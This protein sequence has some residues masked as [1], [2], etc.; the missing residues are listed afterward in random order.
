[1]VSG[2]G[3]AVLFESDD[4]EEEEED[5]EKFAL[6]RTRNWSDVHGDGGSKGHGVEMVIDCND[7]TQILM[8][9]VLLQWKDQAEGEEG[10]EGVDF[11]PPSP[12]PFKPV[13]RRTSLIQM[14]KR[15]GENRIPIGEEKE[16]GS[17]GGSSRSKQGMIAQT[18]GLESFM[19]NPGGSLGSKSGPSL[20]VAPP[21][22]GASLNAS[23]HPVSS[24]AKRFQLSQASQSMHIDDMQ[25]DT[26][27]TDG[28]L[29]ESS[30][31]YNTDSSI[32]EPTQPRNKNIN[33]R[34]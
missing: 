16:A 8:L 5:E 23:M 19:L 13:N 17:G 4:D 24:Y 22:L 1:M 10:E 25:H 20:T 2:G 3:R 21:S 9:L 15:S 6:V 12:E 31:R 11:V 28:S 18:V 14:K 30:E 32:V 7:E 26:T 34:Q 27:A 33:H 29:H